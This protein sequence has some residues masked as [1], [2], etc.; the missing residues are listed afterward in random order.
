MNG[1]TEVWQRR[2][3]ATGRGQISRGRLAAIALAVSFSAYIISSLQPVFENPGL[4]LLIDSLRV[5]GLLVV[6]L[7]YLKYVKINLLFLGL[8]A[9]AVAGVVVARD[10]FFAQLVVGLL[11]ARLLFKAGFESLVG[12]A[13]EVSLL[14]LC[15]IVAGVKFGY[16]DSKVGINP[17][18]ATSTAFVVEKKE[19]WGFWQP[20]IISMLVSGCLIAAFYLGRSRLYWVAMLVYLMVLTGTV[21]RTFLVVPVLTLLFIWIDQAG[22]SKRPAVLGGLL[23]GALSA[24]FM[25]VLFVFPNALRSIVG[26]AV[27]HNLDNILS[28]RLVIAERIM[29]PLTPFELLTGWHDKKAEVDSF[30]INFALS[31]GVLIYLVLVG[32]LG[33]VSVQ[34]FKQKKSREL[35]VLLLFLVVANFEKISGISSLFYLCSCCCLFCVMS[36]RSTAY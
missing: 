22:L 24:C 3:P 16:I 36:R 8:A 1:K 6:L 18:A 5:L 7:V 4:R 21:S 23:L 29:H 26:Q 11:F 9:L 14:F 13:L 28:Y 35:M 12:R 31:Q 15:V 34:A 10:V 20:N 30:F 33:Y 32:Y 2:N 27:Y 25:S 19:Y 17:L